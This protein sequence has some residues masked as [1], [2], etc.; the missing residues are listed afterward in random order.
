MKR[1]IV[2]E[3]NPD[4]AANLVRNMGR[5]LEVEAVHTPDLYSARG[6]L[7]TWHPDVALID[8]KLLDSDPPQTIEALGELS[9]SC[10]FIV[11]TGQVGLEADSL[12]KLAIKN[13]ARNFVQKD[14][15]AVG[16]WQMLAGIIRDAFLWDLANGRKKTQPLKP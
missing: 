13:G 10:P 6:L 4:E 15:V 3:D 9:K 14:H 7:G 16:G 11:L 12:R 5:L 8:L 1:L 2:I